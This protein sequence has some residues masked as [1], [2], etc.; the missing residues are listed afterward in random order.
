MKIGDLVQWKGYL[1]IVIK[2]EPKFITVHS[3]MS[4]NTSG[5]PADWLNS[6]ETDN[7]CP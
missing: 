2:V 6:L 1:Y 7:F 4:G 3:I 5:F